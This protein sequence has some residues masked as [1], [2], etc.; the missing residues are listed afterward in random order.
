MKD[1]KAYGQDQGA[2]SSDKAE[3]K[4]HPNNK[5]ANSVKLPE[6]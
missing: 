1:G 3:G 2:N 6:T 4:P 5:E